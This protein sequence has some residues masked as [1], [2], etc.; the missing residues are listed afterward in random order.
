MGKLFVIVK[1]VE[2]ELEEERRKNEILERELARSGENERGI[3]ERY[4]E[5][6]KREFESTMNRVLREE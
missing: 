3:L 4:K 6:V 5:E 1:M 2:E